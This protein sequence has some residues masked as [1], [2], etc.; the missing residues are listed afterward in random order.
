M[1]TAADKNRQAF[2][3]LFGEPAL[4]SRVSA[5]RIG[6]ISGSDATGHAGRLL[7]EALG[8]VLG[9]LWLHID[10]AGPL[11]SVV[12]ESAHA[13]ATSGTLPCQLSE[14]WAPPYNVVIAVG[15]VEAVD[16]GPV[17]RVGADGWVVSAGSLARVGDS[18]VPVGPAAAAALAGAEAF[19]HVFSAALGEGMST[20]LG[21]LEWNTW[22]LGQSGEAPILQPVN[23]QHTHA[24]GVGAVTHGFLWSL[25]RWPASVEGKLLLIDHD[26]YDASNGQRYAGMRFSDVGHSKADVVA[27]RLKA[28]HRRLEALPFLLNLNTYF[29][30]HEPCPNVRLAIVGLDS[31][32]SRRHAALKLP[33][34]AVNMWTERNYLGTARFGFAGGW[35]CLICAYPE[36]LHESRDEPAVVSSQLGLSPSRVRHLLD[37]GEGL[38]AQDATTV[39]QRAGLSPDTL[40][41]RPLRTALHQVCATGR[42]VLP[43]VSRAVDVPFAFSSLLAGTIGFVTFLRELWITSD[44]PTRWVY[45]VFRRPNPGLLEGASKKLGCYLCGTDD[46]EALVRSR[47]LA[48]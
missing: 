43:E 8:D 30:V 38:T 42:V 33:Q 23:L 16:A 7:A 14:G 47:V 37:T 39:A 12:L 34:R 27:E 3:G 22:S 4:A 19:K 1:T 13:A 45:N 25:Q 32:E 26:I 11:S 41:G 5:I 15:K 35:P 48:T 6:V 24:F 44:S 21:D 17:V 10:A 31:P 36:L 20:C 28:A 9:R 2:T 46:A 40:A 29:D 18:P